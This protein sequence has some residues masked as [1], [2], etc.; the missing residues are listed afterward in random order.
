MNEKETHDQRK[1]PNLALYTVR[2]PF[3]TT[4]TLGTSTCS[5]CPGGKYCHTSTYYGARAFDVAPEPRVAANAYTRLVNGTL[6]YAQ[7]YARAY[8]YADGL[9]GV[10]VEVRS[11]AGNRR[12]RYYHVRPKSNLPAPPSSGGP[13]AWQAIGTMNAFGSGSFLLGTVYTSGACQTNFVHVH[14]D[15]A[16]A[17]NGRNSGGDYDWINCSLSSGGSLSS[18]TD[19]FHI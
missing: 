6:Y 17:E 16:Y 5:A 19:L 9:C 7:V 12:I 4:S 8:R 2:S 11:S 10:D 1:D 14:V 3:P 13:G 15:T 18:A